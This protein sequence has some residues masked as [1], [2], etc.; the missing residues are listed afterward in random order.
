MTK[1]NT[2]FRLFGKRNNRKK[3]VLSGFHYWALSRR[4]KVYTINKSNM[5]TTR[6]VG[7]NVIWLLPYFM[8]ISDVY[9]FL[10]IQL[11]AD[12]DYGR[13]EMLIYE[14]DE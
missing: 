5:W 4:R 14:I 1:N 11:C 7:K 13:E 12:F 10:C 8:D 6:V 3:I 2:K 9:L